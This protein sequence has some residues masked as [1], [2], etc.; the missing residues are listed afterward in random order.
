MAPPAALGEAVDD[1]GAALREARD[2]LAFGA[3][4]LL[5]GVGVGDLDVGAA[6]EAMAAGQAAGVEPEGASR[7]DVGAVQR[8]QPVRRP[9]EIDDVS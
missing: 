2:H 8:H 4:R 9:D 1:R 3:Q 6:E 7:N 5:V